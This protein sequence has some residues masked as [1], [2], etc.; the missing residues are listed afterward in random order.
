MLAQNQSVVVAHRGGNWAPDNT[1]ANF[2]AS[3]ANQVE[4]VETD[5]WL[6]KD[7]VA[8]VLH[9]DNDGQLG[10]YGLPDEQVFNWTC[11]ELRTKFKLE[12]GE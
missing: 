4:G 8:M 6:S 7:G 1:I 10:L 5:V 12:N 9:G 11:E 3:V 2:K